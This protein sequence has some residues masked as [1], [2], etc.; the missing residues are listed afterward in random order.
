[1]IF[2]VST[3]VFSQETVSKNIKK[4]YPISSN[5]EL[6]INNKY[7]NIIINGWEKDSIE[8][9]V[10]IDVSHKKIENAKN[11]L[12]RIKPTINVVGNLATIQSEIEQKS[13]NVFSQYFNKAN[14]IDADKSNVQINYII[15]VPVKIALDITNKFGDVIIE[16][17]SGRL[18]TNL[19]HGDMWINEKLTNATIE[20]KYG[21]LKALAVDY[22]TIDL[23]NAELNLVASKDLKLI[24]SGSTIHI[25]TVHTFEIISNKDKIEVLSN[26][27][28]RGNL[29]FSEMKLETLQNEINLTMKVTDFSVSKINALQPLIYIEQESSQI[30]INIEETSFDFKAKLREGVLRIPK[31]FKN[32]KTELIDKVDK[33]RV[34]NAV[35]GN[36]SKG[37]FTI[38]GEKGSIILQE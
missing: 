26:Y 1:V 27:E 3:H 20:L 22:G 24:S 10:A 5:G 11:L 35:Y 16:N 4:V 38:N 14:P 29:K 12:S 37:K 32:I 18:T 30:T 7:G 34:I 21:K 8:I 28:I 17:A 2:I 19:Q 15:N 13:T 23:K 9:N 25:D 33:V 6:S 36:N 31:T